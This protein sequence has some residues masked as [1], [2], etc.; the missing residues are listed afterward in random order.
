MEMLR[1][2]GSEGFSLP[3]LVIERNL[4]SFHSRCKAEREK[5]EE[6][7]DDKVADL[8]DEQKDEQVELSAQINEVLCLFSC[9][10]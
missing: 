9:Q 10:M 4:D 6:K 8:E 3:P 1:V 2:R 7:V 5:E